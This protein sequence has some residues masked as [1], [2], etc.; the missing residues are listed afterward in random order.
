LVSDQ[1]T[2][3][4]F[5]AGNASDLAD[6]AQWMWSHPAEANVMGVNGLCAYQERFTQDQCY[7]T[8]IDVY[9]RLI[10]SK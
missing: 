7:K 8:L 5:E 6:K 10:N 4:L 2:G 9:E 1:Q 3:L